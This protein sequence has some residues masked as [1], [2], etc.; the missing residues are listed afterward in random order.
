MDS[1]IRDFDRQSVVTKIIRNIDYKVDVNVDEFR[2]FHNNIRSVARNIDELMVFL[3]AINI[4]YDI[5][6]LTE[7]WEIPSV[8]LYDIEGYHLYYNEGDINR[9]DGVLVYARTSISEVCKKIYIMQ[10]INVK[11]LEIFFSYCDKTFSVSA[12]Y[13]SP[14]ICCREF[15]FY[16]D[17]YLSHKKKCDCELIVGDLNINIL[18]D[19]ESSVQYLNVLSEYGFVS[20]INEFTR[21]TDRGGSCIDHIF[22][23]SRLFC[24]DDINA[25]VYEHQITDHFPI[26]LHLSLPTN[27]KNKPRAAGILKNFINYDTLNRGLATVNW[28]TSLNH[29]SVDDVALSMVNTVKELIHKS[30]YTKYIKDKSKYLKP[31]ITRALLVSIKNKNKLYK[32]YKA[33]IISLDQYKAYRN[34]LTALIRR[35]KMGYYKKFI[36]KSK[37]NPKVL[38]KSIKKICNEGD[39]KLRESVTKLMI[40]NNV[41]EKDVDIAN[42]FNRYFSQVG[43]NLANAILNKY[44]EL[45]D[46][47]KTMKKD[48]IFL[49]KVTSE[50]VERE[51]GSLKD[52]KS[53]GIDG[54]T[55]ETVKKIG[56]NIS[57]PL[58]YLANR[59]FTEGR[60]PRVLKTGVV[61]PIYKK[62]D[63]LV[64]GNY[65][66]ITLISVLAKILEKLVKKRLDGFLNKF[67]LLSKNQFGFRENK[68]TQDAI[69]LLVSRIYD[70]VDRR[71]P[72][73]GLFLDLS[74]AFDT[75]HHKTLIKKL[76]AI[77][78]RGVALDL[79]ESYLTGREQYVKV[80]EVLSC[81]LSTSF[82]VPQGTVLGP[83]LFSIYINDLLTID[84][85]GTIISFADDTVILYD[86]NDWNDLKIKMEGDLPR[87]LS[88]LDFNLLTLNVDKTSYLPF[89]SYVSG[90]P[91]YSCLNIH[92]NNQDIK[93]V[94]RGEVR[95]LGI[96]LDCHLR[97]DRHVGFVLK[98]IRSIVPKMKYLKNI[99]PKYMLKTV[100]FALVQSHIFY[101]ILGWGGI[102]K[103]NLHLMN[104]TQ[105][106]ILKIIYN[107]PFMYPSDLLFEE[108]SVFDVR[109]LYAYAMA[110][111]LY[112]NKSS[113]LSFA[114]HG[115]PTSDKRDEK[116]RIDRCNKTIGQRVFTFM[117][118]K[119][120]NLMPPELKNTACGLCTYKR[121]VKGWLRLKETK[122]AIHNMLE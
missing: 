7:V 44:G 111:E 17:G 84:S 37:S 35:S 87:L 81:P 25:L 62:G 96:L 23:K 49:Y 117:C 64:P 119:L 57:E 71:R 58:T 60:F 116:A 48:S 12:V 59:C 22:L 110:L 67:E 104:I 99:L 76:Y 41:V 114:K 113:L 38:W 75:V 70:F 46:V 74:K 55:A 43:G 10:E 107:R 102:Y 63:K 120:Y 42:E 6:I 39:I 66:P 100:Y 103:S 65:R 16:L 98:K 95:Y 91:H 51:I 80:G 101:G 4:E 18:D 108:A 82:G 40:H 28:N 118:I 79:I 94:Q 3:N 34:Q 85:T 26:A 52:N 88:W 86:G 47:N 14:T 83:L 78:I 15:I 115:Y 29:E 5:I 109:Q 72:C 30:T 50:E 89:T 11:I 36:E 93:F 33:N 53:P 73:I 56:P 54:L 106:W 20:C 27:S 69:G 68:S 122:K 21:V 121:R 8:C 1:Y 77:G 90:M 13:K 9:S 61:K 32:K 24:E 97:W 19:S 45:P 2:V 92:H 112:K 31:W 105:K